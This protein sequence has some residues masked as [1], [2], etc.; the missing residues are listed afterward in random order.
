[1]PAGGGARRPLRHVADTTGVRARRRDRRRQVELQSP[2]RRDDA[3]PYAHPRADV[4]GAWRPA[5]N[6]LRCA[7]LV[8]RARRD[9]RQARRDV[10]PAGP[11]RPARRLQGP[12]LAHDQHRREYAR[13]VLRRSADPRLR[14]AGG[15]AVRAGRH[16]RVRRQHRRREVGVSHDSPS[17]RVRLRHLAEGRVEIQRRRE[18][19]VGRLAGREARAGLRSDRIHLVR[20]LRGQPARRQPVRQLDHLPP[21]GDW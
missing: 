3:E 16:P 4:L 14:R 12:R 21:R 15:A 8:L 18:R 5:A 7:Q 13:R 10:R 17:R 2:R 11:D 19:V 1:M 9:N 20:L 6:L